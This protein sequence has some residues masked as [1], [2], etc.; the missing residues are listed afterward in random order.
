MIL[1]RGQQLFQYTW[2]IFWIVFSA[3]WVHSMYEFQRH[4]FV[5]YP[6]YVA[7]SREYTHVIVECCAF[8]FGVALILYTNVRA[9]RN[10]AFVV[11]Q[12][13]AIFLIQKIFKSGRT[14]LDGPLYVVIGLLFIPTLREH[15]NV[16]AWA[17]VNALILGRWAC[18]LTGVQDG[19]AGDE[20]W[21]GLDQ[22]DGKYRIP[23]ALFES[24]FMCAMGLIIAK[25]RRVNGVYCAIGYCIFRIINDAFRPKVGINYA[26]YSAATIALYIFY[27]II[28]SRDKSNK[29]CHES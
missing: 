21:W 13:A 5:E 18:F 3:H 11:I 4:F 23:S 26:Y 10:V 27:A 14:Q 7:V 24:L 9:I 29:V 8:F 25:T 22:G 15:A 20:V 16:L 17:W 12:Y 28:A 6:I 1:T 2:C 19:T